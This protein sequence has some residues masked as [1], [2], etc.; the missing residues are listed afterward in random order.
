LNASQ[1]LGRI[2]PLAAHLDS[3]IG[4]GFGSAFGS[5]AELCLPDPMTSENDPKENRARQENAELCI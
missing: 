4:A 1:I 3:E 2:W 5:E